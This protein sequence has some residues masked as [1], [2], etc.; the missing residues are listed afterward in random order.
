MDEKNVEVASELVKEYE[1]MPLLGPNSLM[2]SLNMS[3]TKI[4]YPFY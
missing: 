2:L 1:G 4:F 3:I